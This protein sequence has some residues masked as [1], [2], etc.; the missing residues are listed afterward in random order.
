MYQCLSEPAEFY[1]RYDKNTLA[2]FFLGHVLYIDK[3]ENDKTTASV[4]TVQEKLTRTLCPLIWHSCSP[5]APE[6]TRNS[7]GN[8]IPKLDVFQ[9][10]NDIVHVLQNTKKRRKYFFIFYYSYK[11]KTHKNITK[12]IQNSTSTNPWWNYVAKKNILELR[13]VKTRQ[14]LYHTITAIKPFKVIQGHRFRYQ[15]NAHI[16]LPVS[17]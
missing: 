8:E 11:R 4:K 3:S 1:R 14:G 16:R 7:S 15:S 17:D 5:F 10:Y 2:Y 13:V 9:I 12:T 6:N